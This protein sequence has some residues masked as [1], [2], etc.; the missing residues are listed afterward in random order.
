MRQLHD[1]IY[2][3][4]KQISLKH[5]VLFELYFVLDVYLH[6]DDYKT[7]ICLRHLCIG[8]LSSLS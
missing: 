2:V 1:Q 7:F 3:N 4:H 8:I 5:S 6:Y